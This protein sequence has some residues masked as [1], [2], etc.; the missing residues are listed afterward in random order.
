MLFD[1]PPNAS[2]GLSILGLVILLVSVDSFARSVQLT[3]EIAWGMEPRRPRRLLLRLV[4]MLV[5]LGVIGAVL[6]AQL[7][8]ILARG[9][10]GPAGRPQHASPTPEPADGYTDAP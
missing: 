4:G 9:S 1:S 2:G 3:F 5:L 7:D 10:A 6:G 8:P